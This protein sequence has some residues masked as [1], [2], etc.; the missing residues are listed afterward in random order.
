[1]T[2]NLIITQNCIAKHL[3]K[4]YFLKRYETPFINN[5]I[6]F[7]SMKYLIEHWYDI[8][9]KNYELIKDNNWNFSIIID[10][11][12]KIQYVHYKFDK[13]A[14]IIIKRKGEVFYNKIWEYIVNKYEQRLKR[15]LDIKKEP[16]F[17]LTNSD[18]LFKDAIYTNEQLNELSKYKNV[19]VFNNLKDKTVPESAKIIYNTL[20]KNDRT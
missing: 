2:N 13:N 9:F 8:N 18:S 5:V 7:N 16:L 4:T 6:D 1:M 19:I 17:I 15:M 3:Y 14:K 20:F 11:N 12:V 10:K